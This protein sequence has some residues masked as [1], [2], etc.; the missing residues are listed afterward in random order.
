MNRG[1]I[2][3]HSIKISEEVYEIFLPNNQPFFIEKTSDKENIERLKDY[4]SSK[5]LTLDDTSY[6]YE[7]AKKLHQQERQIMANQYDI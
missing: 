4:I 5:D 6:L 7:L 3:A 2:M 1:T